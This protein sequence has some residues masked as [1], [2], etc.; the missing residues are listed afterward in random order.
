ME[1]A[2]PISPRSRETVMA[3]ASNTGTSNL[4][5][6]STLSPL[7]MYLADLHIVMANVTGYGKNSVLK[8]LR[9]TII[10]SLS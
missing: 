10:T 2:V 5:F 6:A 4:R 7:Q 9:A 1:P 3:V 8:A